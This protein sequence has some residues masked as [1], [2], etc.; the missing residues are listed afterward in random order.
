M[1]LIVQMGIQT[2]ETWG[3]WSLWGMVGTG[4][5]GKAACPVLGKLAHG[6]VSGLPRSL[7]KAALGKNEDPYLFQF[8]N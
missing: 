4:D 1:V 7:F 3:W 6:G 2:Q 5:E 8:S